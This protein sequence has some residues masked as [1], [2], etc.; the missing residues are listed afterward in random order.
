MSMAKNKDLKSV[1][2]DEFFAQTRI[3]KSK[4]KYTWGFAHEIPN[5]VLGVRIEK[6]IGRKPNLSVKIHSEYSGGWRGSRTL[7]IEY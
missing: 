7:D 2:R 6:Q 1:I 5:H 3:R 4:K